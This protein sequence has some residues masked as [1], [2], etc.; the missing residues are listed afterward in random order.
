MKTNANVVFKSPDA[1][2]AAIPIRGLRGDA[3]L[4]DL[5]PRLGAGNFGVDGRVGLGGALFLGGLGSD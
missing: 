1:S 3:P 2:K 5:G 4:L